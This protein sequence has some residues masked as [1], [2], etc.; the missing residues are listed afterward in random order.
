[1]ATAGRVFEAKVFQLHLLEREHLEV[2]RCYTELEECL[3]EWQGKAAVLAAAAQL[4]RAILHHL[5]HEEEF[6]E[7]VSTPLLAEQRKANV[8]IAIRM[9]RIEDE[10][11]KNKLSAVLQL[12]LLSRSWL[13]DHL[14]VEHVSVEPEQC[15]TKLV[16]I[17]RHS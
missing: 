11:G 16:P 5:V 14:V 4:V 12:L 8:E 2:C 17:R 13:N 1:M 15:K 6:L 9:M 7:T 10:I 3:T